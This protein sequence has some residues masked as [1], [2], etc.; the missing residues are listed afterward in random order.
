MRNARMTKPVVGAQLFTLRNF[1]RTMPDVA[2]TLKKVREM[3]Y[4]AVQISGFGPVDPKEVAAV[5]KDLGLNVAATH[6]GWPSFLN[7]L[8]GVIAQHQLWNCRHLAI[9]SLPKEYF[10]L[11]GLKRFLDELKPVAKRLAAEGMDFSYH[12]HNHEFA[13]FGAKTWI[14][15]LYEQAPPEVLKAELDTYWVQAGGG[16]P[17]DWVRRCAGREPLL[18]LKD[19]CITPEREQRFAPIGEGNLNW[20]AILA[21]AE[22]GGVKYLLVEQDQSYERDPFECLAISLR[23]LRTLGYQ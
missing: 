10:S 15:Q 12:N 3:G 2:Q 1:A 18:H 13:R 5:V 17:A 19:M 14:E 22:K 16:D 21:A 9:G 4:T 6:L 8:G 23:N 7:D 20:P 11:E